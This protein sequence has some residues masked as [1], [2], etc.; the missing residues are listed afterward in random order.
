MTIDKLAVSIEKDFD[1]IRAEM[2]EMKADMG[3]MKAEMVGMK[4]A[5]GGVATKDEL[6]SFKDEILNA[7]ADL[8]KVTEGIDARFSAYAVRTNEDISKLQGANKDFDVRLRVV[9]KRG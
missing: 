5:M 9:E 8:R 6:R 3:E 7:I 2:G 4:S 1:R